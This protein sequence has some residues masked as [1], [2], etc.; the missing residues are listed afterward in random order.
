MNGNKPI[1]LF[2]TNIITPYQVD[3]IDDL[4]KYFNV[5]VF[6]VIGNKDK[7][8]WKL[9]YDKAVWIDCSDVNNLQFYAK[10]NRL[11]PDI[12]IC[13]GY[14]IPK[15][16][17][18]LLCAKFHQKQIYIWLERPINTNS[19]IK[20]ILRNIYLHILLPQYNKLL[21]IGR[22]T[23]EAYKKYHKDIIN[24]PYSMNLEK[25]Y[26]ISKNP[27]SQNIRFFSS[28][29][30]IDR[31]NHLELIKAFKE[32]KNDNISLTI[33]GSGILEEKLKYD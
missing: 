8:D 5:N 17:T 11:N 30:L 25:F 19:F 14:G 13:G 10:M 16:I 22:V 20:N 23:I 28:G 33:I 3:F 24:F 6:Y 4:K 1:L 27:T 21:A 32:I 15:A 12:I 7:K 26:S 29:Q 18:T 31:K 9:N 2:V